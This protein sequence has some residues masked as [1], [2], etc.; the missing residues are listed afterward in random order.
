[1]I[2][3]IGAISITILTICACSTTPTET[4][5]E[6]TQSFRANCGNGYVQSSQD[7]VMWYPSGPTGSPQVVYAPPKPN[8]HT[9]T[10]MASCSTG[11][12]VAFVDNSTKPNHPTDPG[13]N[14]AYYSPN[15]LNVG[16]GGNTIGVYGNNGGSGHTIIKLRTV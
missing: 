8:S 9:V 5:I 1:M 3:R 15:C 7:G 13:D 4:P 11:V 16:G 14:V 6:L 2:H 10:G 12:V